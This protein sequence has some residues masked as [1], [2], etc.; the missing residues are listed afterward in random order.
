MS[1]GAP[2]TENIPGPGGQAARAGRGSGSGHRPSTPVNGP[3]TVRYLQDPATAA[4]DPRQLVALAQESEFLREAFGDRYLTRP[5]LLEADRLSGLES[6]L[7]RVFTLLAS[8]PRRLFG[9]DLRATGRAAGMAPEQID[10][11]LR[12]A[13]DTPTC[14][15]RADLYQEAGGFRLLE[16]NIGSALGGPNMGELNRRLLEHPALARFVADAGLHYVDTLASIGELVKAECARRGAADRPVVVLVDVPEN[17]APLAKR[18]HYVARAWSAL[19]LDAL[20]CPLDQLE[21]RSGRLYAEGR[22]VD[23]V[24]RFFILE[25]LLNPDYRRVIEPVLRATEHGKVGLLCRMDAE[26]YGNKGMDALLSDDAHRSAFT[27]E[28]TELI[29]RFVPWARMLR[30]G[31]TTADGEEVDLLDYARAHQSALVLKPTLLHGGAG[32]VP[33]WTVS[34]EEWQERLRTSV[35]GPYMLQQRVRPVTESFPVAG[36]PGV[37]EPLA[38]NWGV[39][40]IDGRYGGTFVRGSRDPDVGVVSLATGAQFGCC[41]HEPGSRAGD[42]P[43]P[44]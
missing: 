33:G 37:T 11:V 7:S 18:L 29:D 10:A 35:G 42:A 12:T 13:Q 36:E 22:A 32:I 41:F 28:E 3:L 40:L 15:G 19:D 31:P 14:L 17:F 39:F 38:L 43:Q 24:Y 9:G 34:Q 2:N 27:P 44:G 6:D 5:I 16:F 26:L 8:L 4:L 30:D 23:L 20:A 1:S 21:E 25:D